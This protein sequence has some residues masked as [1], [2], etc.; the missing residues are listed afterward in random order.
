MTDSTLIPHRG[1]ERV[2]Y[3]FGG[4]M[5][6]IGLLVAF[7]I[8]S[9]GRRFGSL[10][11]GSAG[12]LIIGSLLA[13]LGGVSLFY[14]VRLSS[15]PNKGIRVSP[16]GIYDPQLMRAEVPWTNIRYAGPM[17][18]GGHSVFGIV[19]NAEPPEGRAFQSKILN[20]IQGGPGFGYRRFMFG[21]PLET[22]AQEFEAARAQVTRKTDAPS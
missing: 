5:V 13:L 18:S 2:Y 16:N 12:P 20:A 17:N 22:V 4:L 14:A 10:D 3:L 7:G 9:G 11:Q 19:L 8:L 15:T 1:I 6:V 21:R